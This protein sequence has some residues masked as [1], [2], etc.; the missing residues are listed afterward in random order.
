ME[1]LAYFRMVLVA[2]PYKY[3][4]RNNKYASNLVK[5]SLGLL[6]ISVHGCLRSH[7]QE[8]RDAIEQTPSLDPYP[9]NARLNLKATNPSVAAT[10]LGPTHTIKLTRD[11]RVNGKYNP[12][13]PHFTNCQLSQPQL[14]L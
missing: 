6:P 11:F 4:V 13:W 3:V 14:V 12:E 8:D 1:V 2:L 5:Y 7:A 10:L 9:R